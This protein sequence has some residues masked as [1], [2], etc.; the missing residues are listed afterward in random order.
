MWKVEVLVAQLCL[1]LYNSVNCNPP[2]SSVHGIS[3]AKILEWV[4]MPSS[5]GPFRPRHQTQVSCI[6]G[7]VFTIW[8]NKEALGTWI[9]IKLVSSAVI[10]TLSIVLAGTLATTFFSCHLAFCGSAGKESTCNVGDLGSIPGLGRSPGEGKATHS[11]ILAWRIPIVHG[12]AKSWTRLSG[13]D[14]LVLWEHFR[15]PSHRSR[16]V[17]SQGTQIHGFTSPVPECTL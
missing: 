15:G 3:Q 5:R 10:F 6:A 2:G 4:A 13:F 12:V 11:S 14:F 9:Y 16:A 8:D 7:R 1:T 17:G